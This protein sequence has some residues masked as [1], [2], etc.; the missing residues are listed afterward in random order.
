MQCAAFVNKNAEQ[1]RSLFVE[2]QEGKIELSV[3]DVQREHEWDNFFD[4][5]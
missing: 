5:R 3:R 4:M 2:H 1:L